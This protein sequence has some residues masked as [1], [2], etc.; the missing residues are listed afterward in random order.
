MQ[1]I[2]T[3]H[4]GD[5]HLRLVFHDMEM[6]FSLAANVT[7]GEVARTLDEISKQRYGNPVAIFVT[8][9]QYDC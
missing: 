4:L 6:S 3:E 1:P 7:L 9:K 5:S 2:Q 8:L